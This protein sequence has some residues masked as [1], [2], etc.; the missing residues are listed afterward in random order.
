MTAI[1][2]IIQGTEPVNDVYD[3]FNSRITNMVFICC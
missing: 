1:V 3:E 2:L